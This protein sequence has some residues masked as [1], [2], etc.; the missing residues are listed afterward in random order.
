VLVAWQSPAAFHIPPYLQRPERDA[1]TVMCETTEPA[2][3]EVRYG[4]TRELDR[5]VRESE[6]RRVHELRVTGLA[7]STEY[8]YRVR[9]GEAESDLARFRSAPQPN[10]P[11]RLVVYGDSRSYPERHARAAQRIAECAPDLILHTGDQVE[12]G[13]NR[14]LWKREFFDPLADLLS[15]IPIV[16]AL[17]N[18]EEAASHY[19]EYFALPGNERYFSF[20]FGNAHIVVLDSSAWNDNVR[21]SDEYRWLEQ[22]LAAHRA[23]RWTLVAFHHPLFSAHD[24]RPIHPARWVWCPLFERCGVDLVLTGHDHFYYRSW[25]IGS[26]GNAPPRGIL[27]LTTGGGAAP[28]YRTRDRSYVAAERSTHHIVELNLTDTEIRGRAIDLDG[29]EFDQFTLTKD[30]TPPP[31]FCAF[32]GYELEHAIRGALEAQP[33]TVVAESFP[34]GAG[35]QIA[36]QLS[37]PHRFRVPVAG[38]LSW[39]MPAGT[40]ASGVPVRLEPGQPLVLPIA[41]D[42]RHGFGETLPGMRLEL[43]DERFRNRTIDFAPLKLWPDRTVHAARQAVGPARESD[44][45]AGAGAYPLV[46]ADGRGRAALPTTVL[47]RHNGKRLLLTVRVQDHEARDE[48][49]APK[50]EPDEFASLVRRRHVRVLLAAHGRRQAFLVSIDGNHARSGDATVEGSDPATWTVSSRRMNHDW[51]TEFDIPLEPS[52]E[53][54]PLRVNVVHSDPGALVE[55]CLSPTFDRGTDPDRVPDFRVGD[56]SVDRFARLV[57]D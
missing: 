16:T 27:H 9:C 26:L 32:E 10:Q 50:K 55:D 20:D 56:R 17:G 39:R 54:E 41:I 44:P 35:V 15:R 12:R 4:T 52:G 7:P 31:E 28:L 18:H 43:M 2:A 14:V 5:I 13:T 42:L 21:D 37:I 45:P 19:F 47:F 24:T 33:V 6:P 48:V 23:A 57:L 53:P 11:C 38:R 8:F 1:V 49:T 34:S 25:P 22:D 51:V 40:D 30:A 36:Q 29:R 3:A 46:R